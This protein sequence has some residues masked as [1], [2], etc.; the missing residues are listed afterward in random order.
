MTPKQ[1]LITFLVMDGVLGVLYLAFGDHS[2]WGAFLNLAAEN[3][4]P[5]WYSS[6]QFFLVALTAF[7]CLAVEKQSLSSSVY[8]WAWGVVGILMLALSVDETMQI[9]EALIDGVM[10]GVAGESLRAYFGAT[11]ETDSLLWTVVFAP[12]MIVVGVGLMWFYYLVFKDISKLF[13]GA[14]AALSLLVV[15]AGLEYVEAKVLIDAEEGSM[16]QYH[17]LTFVEEMAEFLAATLL[18]WIHY[19]YAWNLIRK[20]AS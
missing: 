14:L 13:G 8:P 3:N 11:R 19:S 18:V 10:S 5:T 9:H 7:Y 2:E 12:Q 15:A 6:F 16:S 1:V 17:L 20:N 4:L